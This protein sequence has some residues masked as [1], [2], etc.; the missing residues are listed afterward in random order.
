MSNIIAHFIAIVVGA[1]DSR[2]ERTQNWEERMMV[3]V[4]ASQ[5]FWSVIKDVL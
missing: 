2:C 4:R 5:D 1:F 3:A